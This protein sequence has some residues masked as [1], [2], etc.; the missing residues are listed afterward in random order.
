M[1]ESPQSRELLRRVTARLHAVRLARTFYWLSLG[2]AG[3]YGLGLLATRL[4][5][6][7][8]E[9]V[10]PMMLGAVPALA[11]LGGLLWLRRPEPM[12]AARCVD[13]QEQSKDLF[14]TLTL[15]N[16]SCGAYQPLV[17]RDAERFAGQ[18]EPTRV[19]PWRW[20][21]RALHIA[22][23]LVVLL[24]AS[25]YVPTL[26]PFGH[27]AAAKERAARQEDLRM[28]RKATE[29]RR[30]QLTKSDVSADL[31]EA[32]ERQMEA[33][34]A[35]LR[36][37]QPTA[38][39]SNSRVLLDQQQAVGKRWRLGAEALKQLL[40]EKPL[41]QRFGDLSGTR[42]KSWLEN[43][44]KGETGELQQQLAELQQSLEGISRAQDPVKRT[45]AIRQ[46]QQKLD[47]LRDFAQE[48]VDSKPLAAALER[49]LKQLDAMRS[50]P[51]ST[52]SQAEAE[53]L[54]E[55]LKL[56]E[57]ELQQLAQSARD[58]RELEQAL[59][60]LQAARRLNAENRLD[61]ELCENC[62]SLEDYAELY[63]DLMAE[64]GYDV[65]ALGDGEN[66]GDGTGQ[67]AGEVE[68]ENEAITTD[69]KSQTSQSAIQKGKL[70]LSLKTKGVTENDEEVQLQ[71]ETAVR[72]L[73]Q[74]VS[75]VIDQ[76]QIPPGYH[77][78]I[79]QYFD[80]LDRTGADN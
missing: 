19:I 62:Q 29:V 37:M 70:L 49:A 7:F 47:E 67:G 46:M 60:V 38:P 55:S 21:R 20:G 80:T 12:E 31:S 52:T 78:G 23:A 27:V 16:G 9:W 5:G 40:S 26:D 54:S 68:P 14:L 43:L 79:K 36:E 2:L 50:D 10:S 17:V 11:L 59:E 74:S 72:D 64:L 63:A 35:A 33:L 61:G 56:A 8:P 25:L 71:Y 22:G 4:T 69:F 30:S 51:T 65:A 53:A 24:L 41:T 3:A 75:E 45:E 77:D 15:L 66:P 57:L 48:Q 39:E 42:P 34:K 13:Q 18:V 76:E 6:L 44:R 1:H 28:I 58:L 73:R 32:V